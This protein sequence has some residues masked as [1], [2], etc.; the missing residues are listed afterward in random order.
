MK[1][2]QQCHYLLFQVLAVLLLLG[3]ITVDLHA[4]SDPARAAVESY[5]AAQHKGDW[6]AFVGAFDPQDISTFKYNF[7]TTYGGRITQMDTTVLRPSYFGVR[8][9]SD[10]GKVDSV[11][12]VAGVFRMILDVMP[13]LREMMMG[14]KETILGSVDEG[15]DLKHFVLRVKASVQN[16]AVSNI[17]VVTVRKVGTQWRVVGKR[18]M[19]Q[20]TNLLKRIIR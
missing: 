9:L 17:E 16:E 5:L 11:T 19:E 14:A 15:A 18:N 12:Y 13:P 6:T 2:L 4:Q 1:N 7:V 3:C 8:S 20:M 10:L